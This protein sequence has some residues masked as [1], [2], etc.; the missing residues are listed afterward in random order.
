[1][2]STCFAWSVM[3]ALF[4][5]P[6][7]RNSDRTS[8]YPHYDTVLHLTEIMFPMPIKEIKNFERMT[9]ISINVYMIEYNDTR[10]RHNVIGLIY[11]TNRKLDR[12]VNLLSVESED[13]LL[14]LSS[15]NGVEKN[16]LG[17]LSP[18]NILNYE[19]YERQIKVPFVI[20]VDFECLLKPIPNLPAN[21]TAGES[22]TL[23][24]HTH[25]PYSFGYHIVS[26]FG[27][28]LTKYECYTGEDCPTQF[29]SRVTE[30]VRNIYNNH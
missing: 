26:S 15:H 11:F 7:G 4:P 29:V 19:Y 18:R 22:Y 8:S 21:P 27:S 24:T 14:L 20:Y 28:N 17:E 23:D 16:K 1:M 30:D 5:P 25:V 13:D 12:H 9:D 10:K 6:D 3:A 2:D